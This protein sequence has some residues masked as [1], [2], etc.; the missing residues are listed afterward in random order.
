MGSQRVGHDWATKLNWTECLNTQQYSPKL[1]LSSNCDYFLVPILH[2]HQTNILTIPLQ[3][4][5]NTDYESCDTYPVGMPAS[6]LPSLFVPILQLISQ[7]LLPPQGQP[8]CLELKRVWDFTPLAR[9]QFNKLQFHGFSRIFKAEAMKLLCQRQRIVF[10]LSVFLTTVIVIA[11]VL[12]FCASFPSP[13]ARRVM[14][15]GSGDLHTL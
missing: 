3:T 4:T 7:T 14:W 12:A 10:C 8:N 13:D 11:R 2:S 15:R 9:W 5:A 6:Y 1:I